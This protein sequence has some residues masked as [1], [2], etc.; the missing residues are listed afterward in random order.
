M[1]RL[2][3]LFEYAA[4]MTVRG[5]VRLSPFSLVEAAGSGIGLVFYT[6]DRGHRRLATA[7]LT[8][9]FPHRTPAECRAIARRTFT[10]GACSPRC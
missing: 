9:A 7:N 6:V 5:I 10:P 4:V 3:Y 8:A 2:R 1:K